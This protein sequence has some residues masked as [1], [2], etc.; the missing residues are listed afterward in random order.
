MALN[1]IGTDLARTPSLVLVR[2]WQ[3]LRA[4]R[5]FPLLPSLMLLVVLVIPAIFAG[6]LRP[7]T[8][9]KVISMTGCYHQLG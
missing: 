2:L 7:T 3:G 5:R 4:A 9:I 6:Q 8:Q 1:S